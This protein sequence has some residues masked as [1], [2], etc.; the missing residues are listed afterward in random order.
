MRKAVLVLRSGLLWAVGWLHLAVMGSA[1][2]V[3][4]CLIDPR[5]TDGLSRLACRNVL[6]LAGASLEVRR[7]PG[8]DPSRTC[9][10]AVNHVNLFDP[11]VLYSAI[12]QFAR[13]LELESHFSIPFY[14]WLMKRMG[15]V[16]VPAIKGPADLRR[17]WQL[18]RGALDRGTSLVVFPE[19]KR[20][21]DGSVGPFRDGVFRM[22]QRFGVP[23]VPVTIAGS[24]ELCHKGTWLLRP[25]R[26][27]V[28]L[29]DAIETAGLGRDDVARLRDQARERVISGLSRGS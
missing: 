8:F 18:A 14:G 22:A 17:M 19:G 24:F 21:R 9:L 10:F 13:G 20:T 29:H 28:T 23:I 27:V 15:N 2:T 3:L 6:R 26:V 4:A 25:A 1:L 7:A 12:P 5:R 16:P 11:F